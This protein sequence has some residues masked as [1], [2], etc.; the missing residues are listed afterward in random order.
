[1][2]VIRDY[3]MGFYERISGLRVK[4]VFMLVR[5]CENCN[6]LLIIGTDCFSCKLKANINKNKSVVIY[7]D[8]FEVKEWRN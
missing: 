6:E 7:A 8:T 3:S 5:I 4:S 2:E 1:M